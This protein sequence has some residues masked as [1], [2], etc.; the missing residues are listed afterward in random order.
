MR[1][2]ACVA[3]VVLGGVLLSSGKAS[4]E[5]S[6]RATLSYS[7]LIS[8]GAINA[9]S[10]NVLIQKGFATR[11]LMAEDALENLERNV[12]FVEVLK[13]YSLSLKRTS[14]NADKA[15]RKLIG[16]LCDITTYLERQ[17]DALKKWIA[18]PES[19][20][21]KILYEGYCERVEKAVESMLKR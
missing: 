8:Y 18:D 16:D 9:Y 2:M 10:T 7:E 21:S 4:E 13:R 17:T 20:S 19:E 15:T 11:C 14:P 5:S 1:V 3:M 6:F 12:A